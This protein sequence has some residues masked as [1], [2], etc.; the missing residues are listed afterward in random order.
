VPLAAALCWL[1]GL[2]HWRRTAAAIALVTGVLGAVFAGGL[3]RAATPVEV[4]VRATLVASLAVIVGSTVELWRAGRD[5]RAT[6]PRRELA[7]SG[8]AAG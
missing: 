2:L 7:A 1:A 6:R 8:D 3:E 5:E 4:G